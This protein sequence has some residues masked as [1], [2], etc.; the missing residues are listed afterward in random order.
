MAISFIASKEFNS[1]TNATSYTI[2][3]PLPTGLLL[4]DVCA[5]AIACPST[6]S[7][8][9]TF[10]GWTLVRQVNNGA[11]NHCG[12]IWYRVIEVTDT[13]LTDFTFDPAGTPEGIA[14]ISSLYRGVDT[15]T[16]FLVQDASFA[17]MNSG[18]SQ[19]LLSPTVNN[20]DATAWAVSAGILSDNDNPSSDSTVT[21]STSASS[22]WTTTERNDISMGEATSVHS[23]GFYDSNGVIT[24]G[25]KSVTHR[26]GLTSTACDMVSWI[27]ILKPASSATSANAEATTQ[28]ATTNA[29]LAGHGNLAGSVALMAVAND[30]TVFIGETGNAELVSVTATASNATVAVKSNV[31]TAEARADAWGSGTDNDL[32]SSIPGLTQ[33]GYV[34]PG[35]A[36]EDL[37][38][39]IHIQPNTG[40]AGVTSVAEGATAGEPTA[41]APA[42][43]AAVSVVSNDAAFDYA[44]AESVSTTSVANDATVIIGVN[45][46]ENLVP[47]AANSATVLAGE[48][49]HAE[50]VPVSSTASSPTASL[51]AAAQTVTVSVAAEDAAGF[52]GKQGNAESVQVSVQVENATVPRTALAG[53]VTATTLANDA[54]ASTDTEVDA[55]H[56]P[57]TVTAYDAAFD[58]APAGGVSASVTANNATVTTAAETFAP[59][60]EVPVTAT[61]FGP[62]VATKANAGTVT[63]SA[64][65]DAA[66]SVVGAAAQEIAAT[67]TVSGALGGAG[68]IAG[69]VTVSS[70]ANDSLAG[71]SSNILAEPGLATVTATAYSPMRVYT[72]TPSFRTHDVPDEVREFAVANDL[73]VMTVT[74]DNRVLLV[75]SDGRIFSVQLE[76]RMV[77][78]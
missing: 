56:V 19:D 33:P 30:A 70:T 4:G 45:S 67:A 58:Y 59:A 71:G 17:V 23:V 11:G 35:H 7:G 20:T 22:G 75:A 69:T 48:T 50:D 77:N 13:V 40:H 76:S 28:T 55:G 6:T 52:T 29:P 24:T 18:T 9:P 42:G 16:P 37:D 57:V 34:Q 31:G 25:N 1:D 43:I 2:T 72:G 32:L 65:L 12:S 38:L 53:T 10:T 66:K 61:V 74:A 54:T 41:S 47:V 21:W 8:T 5:I 44:P 46:G 78:A 49:G 39:K 68:G 36:S 62:S 60:G 26:G 64:V 14:W 15:T 63:A 27:G 3:A 73:R 51:G